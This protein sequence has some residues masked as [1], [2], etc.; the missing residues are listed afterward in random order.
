MRALWQR[1]G[2]TGIGVPEDAIAALASELAGRDLGDFFARYVDGTEDPPLAELLAA[3]R[4]D[5]QPAR[6][7]GRR[8]PRRQAGQVGLARRWRRPRCWLGAKVAGATEPKLQHVY[9]GWPRRARRSRRRR[10]RR[11]DRR[12]ACVGRID[13]QAPRGDA[14]QAR[15]GDR[16]RVPPRRADRA[17]LVLESRTARHVL[18]HARAPR[19]TTTTRARRDAWLGIAASPATEG[20]RVAVARRGSR[21]RANRRCSRSSLDEWVER[22]WVPA[23]AAAERSYSFTAGLSV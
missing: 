9:H 19:S 13:P 21:A 12:A 2:Q 20:P 3:F 17:E 8:R 11:R 18:A 14:A 15:C 5:A 16:A 22:H 10:H 7:V 1:Y 6:V 4:R 23:V